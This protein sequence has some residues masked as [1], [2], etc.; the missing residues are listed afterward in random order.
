MRFSLFLVFMVVVACTPNV[1]LVP[2]PV[3]AANI[4][5]NGNQ[6]SH[7]RFWVVFCMKDGSERAVLNPK[8]ENE[9]I[10]GKEHVQRVCRA[11]EIDFGGCY[12]EVALQVSAEDIESLLSRETYYSAGIMPR[13][14]IGG[15][16]LDQ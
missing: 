16:G 3:T 6:Q 2:V 14:H 12:D 11:D 5:A 7:D 10:L 15:C 9:V 1:R 4:S 13:P 8:L